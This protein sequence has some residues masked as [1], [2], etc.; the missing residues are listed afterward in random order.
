[1]SVLSYVGFSFKSVLGFGQNECRSDVVSVRTWVLR[2]VAPG[3]HYAA[4]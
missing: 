3:L 2:L 4:G 1:M